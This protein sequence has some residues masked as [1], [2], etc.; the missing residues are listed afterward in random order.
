MG[1]RV[2]V[3]DLTVAGAAGEPVAP[4]AVQPG[5]HDAH[6]VG[7]EGRRDQAAGDGFAS[8]LDLEGPA[9]QIE[10]VVG[11]ARSRREIDIEEPAVGGQEPIRLAG[12]LEEDLGELIPEEVGLDCGHGNT[13]AFRIG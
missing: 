9:L 4:R 3:H 5:E 13:P 12:L 1:E 7:V 11:R 10:V 8:A 2:D 6:I